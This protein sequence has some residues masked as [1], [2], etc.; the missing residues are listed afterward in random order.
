MRRQ[1]A[2]VL[3]CTPVLAL[4]TAAC[5]TDGDD[6][7]VASPTSGGT[8]ASATPHGY[9]EG[10]EEAKEPQLR[11]A[12]SGDDT[13]TLVDLLTG[14]TVTRMDAPSLTGADNRYLFTSDDAGTT[15]IDS[16]VWTVDH[17]D[18]FHYYRSDPAVVG[19]ATGEKPGHVVSAGSRVSKFSDGNGEVETYD[20][21]ALEDAAK[22]GEGTMPDPATEFEVGAHHGVAVPFDDHVVSTLAPGD[23]DELPDTLGA[24]DESGK[25]TGL[26]G[27][28]SCPDIHGAVGTD[29]AALFACA[30]GVLV[31]TDGGDGAL[32]GRLIA[33]PG[34]AQ[35]RAWSLT[36]GR[37]LV[38]AAFED[39]GLGLLD[40]EEGS[41]T[42]AA[43]DAPVTSVAVSPDNKVVFALDEDGTGYA[44]DPATGEVT[45]QKKLVAPAAATGDGDTGDGEAAPALALSSERGYVSDPE[46]GKVTE[47]D[48]RDGLRETRSFGLGGHPS[49]IAVVGGR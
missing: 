9:V 15:A 10:A 31:I 1:Y 22:S 38:A 24:F 40:P 37:S 18:H 36:S 11:L 7:T 43:T 49:A 46:A 29:D 30:D 2:A 28:T 12:V 21:S 33:Y 34:G 42:T 17:G 5:G 35:G 25:K 32:T 6:G 16:G 44:V 45:A 48:V 23:A 13:L 14:D 4:S 20:R 41:W 27:E 19:T 8:V 39:G 26:A 47:F 3:L